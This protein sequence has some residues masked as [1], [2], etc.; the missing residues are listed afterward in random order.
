MS[1]LAISWI[2]TTEG[3]L[4]VT[5]EQFKT[6]LLMGLATTLVGIAGF[7]A[8]SMWQLNERMAVIIERVGFHEK[9][10]MIMRQDIKEVRYNMTRP[11]EE[12]KK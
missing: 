11:P 4:R 5:F 2:E 6:A 9:E 10:L 1:T 12:G 3:V 8:T 7:M